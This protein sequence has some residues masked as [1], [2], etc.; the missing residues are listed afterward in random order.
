MEN[1][2]IEEVQESHEE[3]W[4]SIPGVVG[5]GIGECEGSPCIQIMVEKKTDS[6]SARIPSRIEG[7]V[8]NI[9]E[10]GAFRALPDEKE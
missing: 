7:Y 10:T 8:V 3:E 2:S 4:L 1:K 9:K 5:V 6:L